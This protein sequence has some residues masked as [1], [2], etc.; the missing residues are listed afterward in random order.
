M[1]RELFFLFFAGIPAEDTGGFPLYPLGRWLFPLGICLLAVG[2]RMERS[3]ASRLFA[4]IRYGKRGKWWTAHFCRH[5]LYGVLT[6]AAL[7]ASGLLVQLLLTGTQPDRQGMEAMAAVCILWIVHMMTLLAL[8]FFMELFMKTAEQRNL[9]PPAL[10][11]LEGMSFLYGHYH[12]RP[13]AF[14][15]EAGGCIRRAACAMELDTGPF[16][17]WP[18]KRPASRAAVC[19]DMAFWREE[20]R[21][22][23]IYGKCD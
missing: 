16:R 6:G 19:W 7:L 21:R 12:R 23:I 17:F 1:G 18:R 22:P 8:F 13:P 20:R 5:L 9:I 11:L 10:L 3:R 2:F 15:L 14:G 4:A